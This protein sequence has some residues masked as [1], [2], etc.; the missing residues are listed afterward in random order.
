MTK[1]SLFSLVSIL[2]HLHRAAQGVHNLRLLETFWSVYMSSSRNVRTQCDYM[3]FRCTFP[4]TWRS[5]RSK[6]AQNCSDESRCIM[7]RKCILKFTQNLPKRR[8]VLFFV[9]SDAARVLPEIVPSILWEL[10]INLLPAWKSLFRVFL[11]LQ[12]GYSKFHPIVGEKGSIAIL[13]GHHIAPYLRRHQSGNIASSCASKEGYGLP[14]CKDAL[15]SKEVSYFHGLVNGPYM[16]EFR[17]DARMAVDIQFFK[18]EP[19]FTIVM[20]IHNQ[21]EILQ[22]NVM[23]VLA[24]T[25]GILGICSRIW[26][27]Q[28]WVLGT[29]ARSPQDPSELL[30]FTVTTRHRQWK[31]SYSVVSRYVWTHGRRNVGCPFCVDKDSLDSATNISMGDQ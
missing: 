4:R 11:Y 22:K 30:V 19:D 16:Q 20:S 25:T 13:T 24:S 28:W 23:S 29:S 21:V 2:L 12:I 14:L 31:C 26:W 18:R 6:H 10:P 3:L 7:P 27:L 15:L 17:E 5:W 1:G 9:L 8:R